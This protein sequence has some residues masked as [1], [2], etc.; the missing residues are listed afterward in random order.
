MKILI[1]FF[2]LYVR[3]FVCVREC[4]CVTKRQREYSI[5][6]FQILNFRQDV[7]LIFYLLK[8]IYIFIYIVIHR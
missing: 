7:V 6:G 1:R 5:V 3:E 4:M 2:C 8:Y